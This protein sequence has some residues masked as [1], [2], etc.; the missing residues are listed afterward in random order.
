[1]KSALSIPIRRGPWEANE[2]EADGEKVVADF[3]PFLGFPADWSPRLPWFFT[4]ARR[5]M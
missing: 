2:I 3:S 1:M 5:R 4:G